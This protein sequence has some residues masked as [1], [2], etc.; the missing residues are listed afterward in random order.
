MHPAAALVSQ[1][2]Q[3]IGGGDAQGQ[4][5]GHGLRQ[6]TPPSSS[7]RISGPT[8]RAQPVSGQAESAYRAAAKQLNPTDKPTLHQVVADHRQHV[9][10]ATKP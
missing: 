7:T 1:G 10:A 3:P 8:G 6:P 4:T 5:A 2:N 9:E